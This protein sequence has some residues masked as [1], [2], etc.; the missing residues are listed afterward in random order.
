[1]LG[2][3]KLKLVDDVD[4][5]HLTETLF[6]DQYGFQI[7]FGR[8]L[9]FHKKYLRLVSDVSPRDG[10]QDWECSNLALEARLFALS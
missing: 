6:Q 7:I 2:L 9:Y 10:A 1:M 5:A 3:E 8:F 4:G